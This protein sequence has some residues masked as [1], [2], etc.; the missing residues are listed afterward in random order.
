VSGLK[1][2]DDPKVYL[3]IYV[4]VGRC[5]SATSVARVGELVFKSD[6]SFDPVDP[7]LLVRLRDLRS[8][9]RKL[10]RIR[11]NSVYSA[12]DIPWE[13]HDILDEDAYKAALSAYKS[14]CLS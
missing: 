9:I 5:G 6:F 11:G 7:G 1:T 4:Y 12:D 8:Q 2:L 14:E 10:E 13:I 3:T